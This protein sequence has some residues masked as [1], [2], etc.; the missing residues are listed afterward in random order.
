MN[1]FHNSP[2]VSN[3]L[4]SPVER[5]AIARLPTFLDAF[6]AQSFL[7]QLD[8]CSISRRVDIVQCPVTDQITYE[9]AILFPVFYCSHDWAF[10]RV[11]TTFATVKSYDPMAGRPGCDRLSLRN[12][13]H[14][15]TMVVRSWPCLRDVKGTRISE[16]LPPQNIREVWFIG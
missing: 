3:G 10:A 4:A 9:R 13:G 16:A 2:L 8:A 15:T 1:V 11:E 7:R 5:L 6:T 14:F 12:M